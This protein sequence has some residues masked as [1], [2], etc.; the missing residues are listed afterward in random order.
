M[1]ALNFSEFAKWLLYRDQTMN[2][3]Y[4]SALDV[5]SGSQSSLSSSTSAAASC[6]C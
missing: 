6:N 1:M 2:T 3:V 5:T 4:S